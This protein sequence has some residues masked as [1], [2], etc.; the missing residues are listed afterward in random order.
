M[1]HPHTAA[2][3][4]KYWRLTE[5]KLDAFGIQHFGS[6]QSDYWKVC[7]R[8]SDKLGLRHPHDFSSRAA[9][10]HFINKVK[11]SFY[12]QPDLWTQ[13]FYPDHGW[14]NTEICD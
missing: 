9:A 11:S 6:G 2:S 3:T 4:F 13:E 1:K 10:D 7:I 14:E 5:P 12:I 8:W